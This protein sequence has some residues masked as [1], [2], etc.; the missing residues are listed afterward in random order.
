MAFGGKNSDIDGFMPYL[1]NADCIAGCPSTA[2]ISGAILERPSLALL[3]GAGTRSQRM[4]AP[5]LPR[6]QSCR[7]AIVIEH[8]SPILLQSEE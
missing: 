5:A 4:R 6:A 3:H 8:L 7:A 1:L 2:V